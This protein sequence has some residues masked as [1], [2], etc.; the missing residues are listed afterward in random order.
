M[1][2]VAVLGFLY[3]YFIK[4][5]HPTEVSKL[6]DIQDM[7]WHSIPL[8]GKTICIDGSAYEIYVRKGSSKTLSFTLLVAAPVGM[9]LAPASRFP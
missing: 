5:A 1:L 3:L 7:D 4:F 9:A 2:T 8:G 6:E